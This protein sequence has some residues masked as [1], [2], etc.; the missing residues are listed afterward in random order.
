MNNIDL[1]IDN[2]SIGELK[3]F[4][5]LPKNYTNTDLNKKVSE[6]ESVVNSADSSVNKYETLHFIN[7]AKQIL[8]KKDS[9]EKEKVTEERENIQYNPYNST[10]Q[11][12]NLF[13]TNNNPTQIPMRNPPVNP[14]SS[15]G[16]ILNPGSSSHQSMQTTF[17]EYDS[18]LK[19]DRYI[20]NYVFNTRYRDNFF[21]S[22]SNN[23][24]FTMPLL[25]KNVI[26]ITLSAIQYPNVMYA[27]SNYN[28]TDQIYIHEDTTN[29]KGTVV[30]PP[31][32]YN[33]ITFPPVFEK[34]INDQIIGPGEPARFSVSINI[35]S[36]IVTISNSTYTFTME[37]ITLYPKKLGVDCGTFNYDFTFDM[38]SND[39]KKEPPPNEAYCSL[40]YLIGYRRLVYT[41]EKSYSSEGIFEADRYHYVFFGLNDHVGNQT[42]GTIA[43][44]PQSVSQEDILAFIPI[45]SP[46]FETT[47]ADGSTYIYRTRNYNGPVD[48]SKISVKLINPMGQLADIHQSE[49]TFCLQFGII[50]DMTKK[51]E[52]ISV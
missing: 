43:M 40:G 12:S 44:F 22:S 48:I 2:Y 37:I 16:Q 28:H 31:G 33:V 4:L 26:S 50:V 41:G 27:I 8:I 13:N 51:F 25:V 39:P 47:F 38:G 23:C 24:S 5:K 32:N 10:S 15:I 3:T 45:S 46:Q 36:H 14:N 21:G 11:S 1:N 29:Y 17:M 7:Q 42:R 9:N 35:N 20:R 30:M 34:A 18:P 19:Y 49:F 6:I 52:Y